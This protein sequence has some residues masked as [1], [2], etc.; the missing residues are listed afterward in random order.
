[1]TATVIS[2]VLRMKSATMLIATLGAS[3]VDAVP[4]VAGPDRFAHVLVSEVTQPPV[5]WVEFCV[6]QPN[7]CAGTTTAP[8]DVALS[9]EAW[10]ALMRVNKWVNETIKP[11]ADLEHWGLAERWSYPDDGYGDCEDYVLL[12]RRV[13]IQSGWPREAL[14]VTMVRDKKG[15]R[16]CRPDGDYRQ[17]RLRPRQSE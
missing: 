1:M 8:R 17:G 12:K 2:K 15:R 5:G 6:R 11:L 14:L 3:F 9:P 7:E 4:A 10:K 16:S 13:L